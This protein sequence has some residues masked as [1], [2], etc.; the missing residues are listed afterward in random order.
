MDP[1]APLHPDTEQKIHDVGGKLRQL[2]AG[3]ARICDIA[4]PRYSQM[5]D[6]TVRY[7]DQQIQELFSQLERR[8]LLDD[9]AV[10]ITGDHGE[11][12]G[13]RGVYDHHWHYMFEELLRVPLLVWT[14]GD[15]GNR[16]RISNPFSLAWMHE[17]I[18][19]L[20]G[21]ET[22]PLP[23]TSKTHEHLDD[24]ENGPVVADSVSNNGYSIAI[25]SGT[26]K[27]I[28]QDI[29]SMPYITHKEKFED[30]IVVIDL[31]EDP[32]EN[33]KV[34]SPQIPAEI[35]A[36]LEEHKTEASEVPALSDTLGSE[37]EDRLKKLGYKE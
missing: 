16:Q 34:L 36:L 6:N 22:G 1:H 24:N 37:A 26:L 4:H 29:G 18:A 23:A 12:L 9:A 10:I 33:S 17:L 21:T 8:G 15:D 2:A 20:T 30:D 35:T 11:A 31:E 32:F 28:V 27:Y 19:E 7:V 5:Y 25:R 13:E 3:A 14:S